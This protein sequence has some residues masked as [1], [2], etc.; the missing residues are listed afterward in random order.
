MGEQ[1]AKPRGP[2][3][4]GEDRRVIQDMSA[5]ERLWLLFNPEVKDDNEEEEEPWTV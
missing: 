1:L 3:E 2:E 4:E 5:A